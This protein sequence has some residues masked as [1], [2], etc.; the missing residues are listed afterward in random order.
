MEILPDDGLF[1]E[2]HT[3]QYHS[4]TNCLHRSIHVDSFMEDNPGKPRISKRGFLFPR[5]ILQIDTFRILT[6]NGFTVTVI[7]SSFK[8]DARDWKPEV[9]FYLTTKFCVIPISC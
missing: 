7:R 2:H 1:L 4:V 6:L 9:L 5:V 3:N 8:Y